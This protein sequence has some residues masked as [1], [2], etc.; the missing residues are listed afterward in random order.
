MLKKE[1]PKVEIF[2]E[3]K[4]IGNIRF[5]YSDK[6]GAMGYATDLASRMKKFTDNADIPNLLKHR[7][8]SE[9][10]DK[11]R[12]K[13]MIDLIADPSNCLIFLQSKT[14]DDS[15]LNKSEDWYKIKFSIED[16][17]SELLDLID[18]PV[19][20]N[21]KKLD[22]PVKNTLLPENFAILSGGDKGP[23]LVKKEENMDVWCR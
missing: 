2:D 17:D 1:G 8:V 14:F 23:N 16:F 4:K 10:F 11:N 13:E 6:S 7:F 20:N 9:Y 15:D 12:I 5:D 3:C 21:G 22:L 18:D 19:K